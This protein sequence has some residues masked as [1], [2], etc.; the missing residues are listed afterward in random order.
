[1]C[2]T[3]VTLGLSGDNG[4]CDGNHCRV[5]IGVACVHLCR[6]PG[7]VPSVCGEC[8]EVPYVPAAAHAHAP[9][10]KNLRC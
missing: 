10:G 6:G 1:M 8:M 9:G 7:G 4:K 3:R 2:K 5:Y